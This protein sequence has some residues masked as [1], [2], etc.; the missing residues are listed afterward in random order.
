MSVARFCISNQTATFSLYLHH[1]SL[2]NTAFQHIF[3]NLKR[4]IFSLSFLEGGVLLSYEFL[5]ARM[6]NP[7]FGQSFH[8]WAA[9]LCITLIS[10][11]IGYY[12]GARFFSF[13]NHK[14]LSVPFLVSLSYMLFV[15]ITKDAILSKLIFI[16]LKIGAVLASIFILMPI[17]ICLTMISPAL[18]TFLSHKYDSSIIGSYTGQ[19]YAI[20]TAGGIVNLLAMGIYFIYQYGIQQSVLIL[21]ACLVVCIF[22]SILISFELKKDNSK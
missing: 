17:L 18:I 13:S 14:F 10:M 12:L 20:S 6:L 15:M 21:A 19:I 1:I 9:I 3:M 8:I 22:L 11:S 4:I 5:S 7:Y 2:L 16:N